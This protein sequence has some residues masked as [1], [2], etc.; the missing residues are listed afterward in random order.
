MSDLIQQA[1]GGAILPRDN[2]YRPPGGPA[3]NRKSVRAMR[4]E[5][6]RLLADGT[7]RAAQKLMACVE[8]P[9]N[10]IATVAAN[11]VLEHVRKVAEGPDEEVTGTIDEA[12]LTADE[13]A[14]ALECAEHLQRYIAVAAE[15]RAASEGFIEGEAL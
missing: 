2:G 12:H 15:R 4:K 14:H 7:P 11:L 10:R 6:T 8:D 13:L 9:D 1:H 3:A 5:G